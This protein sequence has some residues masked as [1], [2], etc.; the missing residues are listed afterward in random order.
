MKKKSQGRPI[1]VLKH[2]YTNEGVW[3]MNGM[4]QK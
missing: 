4:Y 1:S 2:L 3:E